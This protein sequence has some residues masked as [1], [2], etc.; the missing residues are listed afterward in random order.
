MKLA[1]VV[2]LLGYHH[3]LGVSRKKFATGRNRRSERFWRIAN[4]VPFLAA[5]VMVLAVTTEFGGG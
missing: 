3:F 2:F 1:G 5:I 4:E